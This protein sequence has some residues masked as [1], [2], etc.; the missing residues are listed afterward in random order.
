MGHNISM[1]QPYTLIHHGGRREV[2][3][4][5]H[6]VRLHDGSGILIDCGLR[7]GQDV[8]E[9]TENDPVPE[10]VGFSVEHLRALVVTHAHIDHVGRIPYLLAAGFSGPILCSEP[11][12]V[13]L[14]LVL[15]DAVKVG[16]TR[17]P[18]M[19][20]AIVDRLRTQIVPVPYGT[21]REIGPGENGT[22]VR[23]KLR[24][25]GHILGSASVEVGIRDRGETRIVFSGDLGAPYTPLLPAPRSPYKAD[26]L[27]L[28]STY[29]D[30]LH[31]DRRGRRKA[32]QRV[33]E[34]AL[35]DGGTVLIPAFS[36]G[37]TQELLY[38]IE[39]LIRANRDRPVTPEHPEL[40]W[41]R[42]EIVV[43]SPLA[44]RFTDAFKRLRPFWDAE[45]HRRLRA[46]R[47][48]LS[49][50]QIYT[51]DSHESHRYTVEYLSQS[52]RPAVVI[53]ASGMCTGGRIINY[54]KAMIAEE[55]NDVVF[56]G[57]QAHGTPGRAIQTYGPRGGWVKLDGRRYTINA[58][59]H[60][61]RSYS[62]HADRS[63][64]LRYARAIRRGPHAIRLI[65]GEPDA[66]AALTEALARE[67]PNITID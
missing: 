66:Q 44:A 17:N 35:T 50:D 6:E 54:L 41:D 36:L 55:R 3:G 28:E 34:H 25:A 60:T 15:E 18:R 53:A 14:P 64:L 10:A 29:G 20:E 9:P 5:C 48:P 59:I 49:F 23:I 42:M 24:V 39:G 38:E 33:L 32:L 2:T 13:L 31:P 65:H 7:Q 21:W 58:R 8:P 37:R 46:G 19:I 40:T 16:I 22:P 11:T 52:G 63:N 30:G 43:D 67:H 57:Y 26:L 45:A 51:V 4:S 56:V 47:H 62:G 1:T 12:A 61:L 27:V